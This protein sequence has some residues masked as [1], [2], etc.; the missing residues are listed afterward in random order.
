MG[1]TNKKRINCKESLESWSFHKSPQKM[2]DLLSCG[3]HGDHMTTQLLTSTSWC[4]VTAPQCYLLKLSTQQNKLKK[5]RSVALSS[6]SNSS[7][8]GKLSIKR[9]G[10]SDLAAALLFNFQIQN[11]Q[12]VGKK[13]KEQ[14]KV[15]FRKFKRW[16][17]EIA[18]LLSSKDPCW[19]LEKSKS[20]LT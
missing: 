14:W 16:S 13:T 10:S 7:L 6:S 11:A 2:M 15:T 3:Y 9:Q 17:G 1:R 5:D 18:H 12:L 19:Y 8:S 20:I 4:I